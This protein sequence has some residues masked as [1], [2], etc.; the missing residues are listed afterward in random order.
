MSMFDDL[1]AQAGGLDLE[2]IGAR[3]GLTPQQ[4]RSGAEALLP[5]IANPAVDNA[6]AT[7]Q[8]AAQTGLS[9]DSLRALIPA[10]VG[11]VG[12]QGGAQGG[13]LGDLISGLGGGQAG[14]D[15]GGLLGNIG[16]M[17]DRDGDGNPLNDVLGM[18]NRR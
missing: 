9:I 6:A 12:G 4:V 18:F 7:E 16:S 14:G 10:I 3:V 11:A 5:G 2:A 1:I 8:A 15:G 13:V 17:L